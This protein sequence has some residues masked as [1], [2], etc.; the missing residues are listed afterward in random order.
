MPAVHN[1][2]KCAAIKVAALICSTLKE[3][4]V[5]AEGVFLHVGVNEVYD[6]DSEER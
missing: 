4:A 3:S 2:A 1:K 5:A 6:N